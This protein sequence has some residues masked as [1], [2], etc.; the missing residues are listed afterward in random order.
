MQTRGC[1]GK[2][3][4]DFGVSV[5][6]MYFPMEIPVCRFP[7]VVTFSCARDGAEGQLQLACLSAAAGGTSSESPKWRPKKKMK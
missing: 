3:R 6:G 7:Q 2:S 4:L 5:A 1:I